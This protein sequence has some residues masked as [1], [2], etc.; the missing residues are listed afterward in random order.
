MDR[1]GDGEAPFEQVGVRRWM[2]SRARVRPRQ[3]ETK[4]Q[5]REKERKRERE[6]ERERGKMG[7]ARNHCNLLKP[8]TWVDLGG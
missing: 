6:R 4:T 1:R 2:G 5:K 3:E 8:L 7:A